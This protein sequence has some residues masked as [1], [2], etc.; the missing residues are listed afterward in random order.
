MINNGEILTLL[1]AKGF[2][3][4]CG[5]MGGEDPIVKGNEFALTSQGLDSWYRIN[6][7]G[8]VDDITHEKVSYKEFYDFLIH[9]CGYD[10]DEAK[11][12][13]ENPLHFDSVLDLL[14][15]QDYSTWFLYFQTDHPELYQII[16]LFCN[17]IKKENNQ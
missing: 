12:T 10:D 9:D 16:E 4:D 8:S 14:D 1:V 5:P 17:L 3:G 15:D 7:D 11:T 6:E 2:E 13:I